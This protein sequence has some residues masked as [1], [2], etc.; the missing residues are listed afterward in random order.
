M[1]EFT[2]HDVE[3]P[4]YW[5]DFD[6]IE[7][8]LSEGNMSEEFL[9][10]QSLF[11][12]EEDPGIE[13]GK[14]SVTYNFTQD[15]MV[16]GAF[17]EHD[18]GD[19]DGSDEHGYVVGSAIIAT[20]QEMDKEFEEYHVDHLSGEETYENVAGM[21]RGIADSLRDFNFKSFMMAHETE[22]YDRDQIESLAKGYSANE[23]SQGMDLAANKLEGKGSVVNPEETL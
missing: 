21:V 23:Y 9:V 12:S 7:E 1:T 6:E 16:F 14:S 19:A 8:G 22:D 3:N 10:R 4:K 15:S 2:P 18:R 11:G 20:L 5:K 13:V 17:E